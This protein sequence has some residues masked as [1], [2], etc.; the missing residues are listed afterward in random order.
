MLN[1]T[2]FPRVYGLLLVALVATCTGST[3][4]II[5]LADGGFVLPDG[6]V[7]Q[8]DGGRVEVNDAGVPPI[9][10]DVAPFGLDAR[11][12][13]PTCVAP[14]PPPN[15]AAAQF[16]RVF[17]NL[18][19]DSPLFILQAPNEPGTMY[20]VEQDGVIK[21]F[22]KRNDAM[23]DDVKV[24][25]KLSSPFVSGGETGLLGFAFHPNWP[26]TREA[27][28]SYTE[29]GPDSPLRSVISRVRSLD[30]GATLALSTEQPVLKLNQ[31]YSNHN[32]GHISFGADGFLYIA[33]GDGGSGGDPLN[34]GQR[35]NTNL[36]KILRLDVNVP[37]AQKYKI[38]STNPFA[39][40]PPCNLND[41]ESNDS[42]NAKCAEIYAWGL[43][44]P[45]RFS[46]DS[47][48]N[49]LWAGDVGQGQ[50]EEVDKIVLGGNYGWNT[51]EGMHCFK[52]AMCDTAGLIDPVIEY[53]HNA[54]KSI[55]GGY[56]YRGKLVPGMVGRYLFGDFSQPSIWTIGYEP[57]TG[58]AKLE[59]ISNA[60]RG[61]SSFG[62]DLEH[63][64]YALSYSTSAIFQ[65]QPPAVQP[66]DTF[67]K[68]LSATGCFD[69]ANPQNPV[70]ALV[71]YGPVA[72]FWSDGATKV[73]H[74]A[75][76]DGTQISLT[77]SG[78]FEFPN[79]TVT[80]KTFLVG[81]KRIETR[82]FMRHMDG[83]WAGY[84]YEWNDDQSDAV[85]LP[86]SKAKPVGT[87]TWNYPSRSQCLG[88]HTG[89]AGYSLGLETA[90][91]DSDFEYAPGR[92]R[93]QMQTLSGL[94]FLKDAVPAGIVPL[95]N[96]GG[97]SAL[98]ARARSYLHTNCSG[99]HQQGMGQ[100]PADYRASL[101]LKDT[102][103][104]NANPGKGD[105][106]IAGAK[107]IAPGDP[108]KS[109][110]SFRIHTLGLNRMPPISSVVEDT[111]GA[112]VVDDWISSLKSCP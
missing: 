7:V 19:F 2:T 41:A 102:K 91:L 107:L 80:A 100:G 67:P 77:P 18:S 95:V 34:S 55:T 76:P 109:L 28:L 6:A 101:S 83:T 30:N 96:P 72:P 8:A 45:W 1:R 20:V 39:K 54:G 47:A 59:L 90:Q 88:C 87:Q 42:D 64:L 23:P 44:N 43:R 49:E 52:N 12:K 50:W 111:V 106:G 13:N 93:N 79:G 103:L 60:V 11:P 71:P 29:D 58:K 65:M 110:V 94:G 61:L 33:F 53:D 26:D 84:T 46:F 112:Q 81:G 10:I 25:V 21:S 68:K 74:F 17:P 104:C 108:A 63:E 5:P 51:R 56:V 98:D 99:C 40:E 70:P 97:N 38:P 69:A 32:G 48:T 4:A 14:A 3:G 15:N 36:G 57:G 78:D 85:L 35:L 24:F 75:I 66:P 92:I 22:P 16:E 27:F 9:P 73:R 105:L 31:P 89:I 82:L 37:A 86:S 62:E